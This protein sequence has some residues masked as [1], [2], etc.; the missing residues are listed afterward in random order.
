[1]GV[2]LLAAFV[3]AGWNRL[4]TLKTRFHLWRVAI[5][6]WLESP[7]LGNGPGVYRRKIFRA[8]AVLNQKDPTIL[9]DEKTP[10]RIESPLARRVHNDYLETLAEIGIVGLA[11]WLGFLYVAIRGA[12]DP[13]II[14]GILAAMIG[15]VFFYPQRVIGIGMPF[16]ALAGIGLAQGSAAVVL[17]V[18]G[19]VS[20]ILAVI[21][22]MLAY[23]FGIQYI[24]GVR[25]FFKGM[26]TNPQKK[27]AVE[28]LQKALV[29]DPKNG[30]YLA[31]AARVHMQTAP[32]L[33]LQYNQ[34]AID[35][36]DGEK[37]EWSLWKQAGA[38]LLANNAVYAARAAF[39]M[40]LYLN[41][42]HKFSAD[43]LRDCD[44][45]IKHIQKQ[46]KKHQG[47]LKKKGGIYV[48]QEREIEILGADGIPCG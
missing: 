11:L 10:G 34:Q 5:M 38:I 14:G 23:K 19:V 46:I 15:M 42:S 8:Q 16:Y 27:Q 45:T 35:H 40:A 29:C 4:Q 36:Y 1:M 44:K 2:P 33:A 13:E 41:P 28:Y 6:I 25:Y 39:G 37:I 48:P 24:R 3:I 12:H 47:S 20:A 17:P 9:G 18:G 26:L 32:A 43:M 21:A 31:E 30:Y 7:I 22:T